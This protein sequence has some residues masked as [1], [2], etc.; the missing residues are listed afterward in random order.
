M[1]LQTGKFD[2]HPGKTPKMDRKDVDPDRNQTC[3]RGL[4][5]AAYIYAK[6]F[7]GNGHLLEVKV[8]P[9]DV[10]AVPPDYNA[11]KM[12]VCEYFVVREC[13]GPRDEKLYPDDSSYNE[14]T[15]Y[16]ED[17]EDDTE[18]DE[19]ELDVSKELADKI[20]HLDSKGRLCIPSSLVKEIGLKPGKDAYVE[21]SNTWSVC[22]FNP[23][24]APEDIRVDRI[25]KV[26]RDCNIRLSGSIVK[27]LKN[28]NNF[29]IES[30]DGFITI[31]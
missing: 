8:N 14:E 28:T 23:K 1:D 29:H 20:Y 21:I 16:D 4:H 2:N 24:N 3:S 22:I 9:K 12:R 18:L 27:T 26:D 6:D 13:A 7:Y 31:S 10:V 17:F 15:A 11:Q 30:E 19:A 5:V 25:Y